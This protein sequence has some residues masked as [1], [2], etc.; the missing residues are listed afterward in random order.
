MG[1]A[2]DLILSDF[3]IESFS[4]TAQK[5]PR[6]DQ[7]E[8]QCALVKISVRN[9]DEYTFKNLYIVGDVDYFPGQAHVYMASGAKR[10]TIQSDRFGTKTFDFPNPLEKGVTY[11]LQLKEVLPEDQQRRTFV[12]LDMGYHLSQLSVGTMI[13]IVAKHGAYLHPRTNF[14]FISPTLSCNDSGILEDG[15]LPYY[16]D[17][18]Y[19]KSHY[20]FT[21]GY[22]YRLFKPVYIYSGA[23][24]GSRTLAWETIDGEIVKNTSHSSEGFALECG[25]IVNYKRWALSLSCQT[26]EFKYFEMGIGFG[27]F[28]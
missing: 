18:E 8:D 12:M 15:T 19:M 13:G 14:N 21:A 23:G 16:K 28:F 1:F 11:V 27:I 25:A 10:I 9:V 17:Q 24:Y 7:N 2:Q 20:S 3:D 4:F 22:M 26:I 6:Y 5:N